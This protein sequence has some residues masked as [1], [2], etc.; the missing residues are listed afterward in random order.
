[1]KSTSF[2]LI[3]YDADTLKASIG[4]NLDIE[5]FQMKMVM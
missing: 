4:K 1:M 5:I 3:R 2:N